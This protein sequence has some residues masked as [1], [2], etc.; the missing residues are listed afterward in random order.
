MVWNILRLLFTR[1]LSISRWNNFPRAVEINHLDNVWFV[2]HVALFLAYIES[3]KSGEPL[4]EFYIMKK[5]IFHSFRDLILSDINSGTK[6]Y[7]KKIDPDIF[8]KIHKKSFDFLFDFDAPEFLKDDMKQ[9]VFDDSERVENQIILA[10]KKYVGYTEALSNAAVFP[11]MYEVP[12]SEIS[13][14]IDEMK[15]DLYCLRELMDN[16]DHQKYLA[17]VNRLS[18]SMRWNHVSRKFPISVMSHLVIVAF[19][20]YIIGMI[21]NEA[22]WDYDIEKMMMKAMY[23]DVPEVIT[24]DIITPTKQAVDGFTLVLEEVE[25]QMLDD[26]LFSYISTEY[27]QRIAEYMLH[28]FSDKLWTVVKYAD[29]MSALLEA[30]LE[31]HHGNADFN[32]VSENLLG[33]AYSFKNSGVDFIIQEMLLWFDKDEIDISLR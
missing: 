26:Y 10:A 11:F 16:T 31:S 9:V 32:E 7:I 18:F 14:Q 5:V 29:V 28:P 27:K 6:E 17:H 13:S 30:R 12:L 19:V 2:L 1:G 23:H 24:G 8:W 33:K 22:G 15:Q 21:E 3:E 4:D 20:S 25:T